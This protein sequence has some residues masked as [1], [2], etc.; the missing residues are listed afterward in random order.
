MKTKFNF[1]LV[2]LM[3]ISFVAF[4]SCEN[5]D[6]TKP[7]ITMHEPKDGDTLLIGDEHGIHLDMELSDDV[8]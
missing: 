6:T 2:C 8:V 3:A 7:V 1:Y 5:G 4:A